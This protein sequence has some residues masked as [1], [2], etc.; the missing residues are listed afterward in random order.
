MIRKVLRPLL[1]LI[2]TGLVPIGCCKES[3]LDYANLRELALYLAESASASAA[4]TT[5]SR[6]TA[7]EL[8]LTV[9]PEY[10]YLAAAPV[11]SWFAG[12]A[13]ALSCPEPGGKGLKDKVADVLFTSTGLFNGVATGQSLQQFVRCSGGN[14]HYQGLDFP[15]SQLAD[16]LNKWKGGDL[17]ELNRIFELRIS[18]KPR[19]NAQQQFQLLIR[20]VSG[21][22]VRQ[23]TP[24]IIWE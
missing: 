24:V 19:D 21:K 20:M 8:I 3:A 1:V 11:G 7:P 15:L 13:M 4:L 9:R 17:G 10:D 6:T 5:G 2:F 12:Q 22:E 18:P 23:S 16:S 14:S